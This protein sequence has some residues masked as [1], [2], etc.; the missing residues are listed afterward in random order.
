[1]FVRA[2]DEVL[3]SFTVEVC[4]P[5]IEAAEDRAASGVEEHQAVLPRLVE[6]YSEAEV[7]AA[8]EI[9]ADRSV[10][11]DVDRAPRD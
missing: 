3:A 7:E 6:A 2:I 8:G 9:G 4:P 11:L 1:M 10:C 5:N